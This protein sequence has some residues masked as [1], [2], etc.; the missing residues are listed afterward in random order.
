[1]VFYS[2]CLWLT[3]NSYIILVHFS[4]SKIKLFSNNYQNQFSIRNCNR[5]PCMHVF[6]WIRKELGWLADSTDRH[7]SDSVAWEGSHIMLFENIAKLACLSSNA[8]LHV[9]GFVGLY[10]GHLCTHMKSLYGL[11][12]IAPLSA[13]PHWARARPYVYRWRHND[14]SVHVQEPQA[15]KVDNEAATRLSIRTDGLSSVLYH[16]DCWFCWY[17]YTAS[18]W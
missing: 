5:N 6:V 9:F 12:I 13:H 8:I 1:M 15:H 16:L 2:C 11:I 4:H 10:A 14:P 18:R 17:I 3:K 7:S